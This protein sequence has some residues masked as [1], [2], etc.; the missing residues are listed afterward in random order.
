MPIPESPKISVDPE[1]DALMAEIRSCLC[2]T[3]VKRVNKHFRI[4]CTDAGAEFD[5]D[6]RNNG[7]G[8]HGWCGWTWE[9]GIPPRF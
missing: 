8:G 6:L 3:L 4:K 1:L 7:N 5:L 2:E 9:K